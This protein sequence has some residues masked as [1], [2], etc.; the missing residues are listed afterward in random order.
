MHK[1]SYLCCRCKTNA[2]VGYIVHRVEVLEEGHTQ[3]GVRSLRSTVGDVRVESGPGNPPVGVL[4]GG[5]KVL[6]GRKGKCRAPNNETKVGSR[7]SG[8]LDETAVVV[9][10]SAGGAEEFGVDGGGD[11]EQGGSRVDDSRGSAGPETGRTE[12]E[13]TD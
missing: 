2:V 5:D 9:Q 7:F 6:G 13:F 11:V 12:C 4:S 10:F 8:E 1:I 3:D